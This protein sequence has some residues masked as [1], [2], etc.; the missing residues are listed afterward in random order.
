[1]FKT[2]LDLPIC[3]KP[4]LTLLVGKPGSNTTGHQVLCAFS[5]F[6]LFPLARVNLK[7]ILLCRIKHSELPHLP[8]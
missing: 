3:F 5:G 6:L 4:K 8:F 7:A 2:G 1:M